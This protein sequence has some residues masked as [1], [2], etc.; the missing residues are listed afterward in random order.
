M[1]A[2]LH[3]SRLLLCSLLGWCASYSLCLG[4]ASSSAVMRIYAKVIEAP[5]VVAA[6]AF[7]LSGKRSKLD[8]AEGTG[9]YIHVSN[10]PVPVHIEGQHTFS[11]IGSRSISFDVPAR[12]PMCRH[13]VAGHHREAY[14]YDV[15]TAKTDTRDSEALPKAIT[16]SIAYAL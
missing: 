15:H 5:R 7:G 13:E 1:F 14:H 9:V 4:Q 11:G 8:D 10:T 12:S 3:L 16:V 6:H 2:E